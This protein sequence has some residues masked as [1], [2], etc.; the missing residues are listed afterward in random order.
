MLELDIKTRDEIV[1]F[2]RAVIVPAQ[3]GAS[4]NQVADILA[5]L[6]GKEEEK[7][8]TEKK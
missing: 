1:R 3:T 6:K 2:L 5:N 8:K 4:L 7:P